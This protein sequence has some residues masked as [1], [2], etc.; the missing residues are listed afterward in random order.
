VIVRAAAPDDAE[1]LAVIY[2]HHVLTGFGTF[3]GEAPSANDMAERLA[4]VQTL[5]LPYLVAEIEGRVSGLA[6]AAPFRPRAAY[7]YTVED[8]IYV[9]PD[10]VGQ[11]VGKRLLGAVIETCQTLGFR[12]MVAM[13]GDSGNAASIA[14][15]RSL[16]FRPVGV[17]EGLGYKAGRWVDVAMMQRALNGGV[18]LPPGEG[19]LDLHGH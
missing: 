3:E 4:A 13:I 12:Q 7:R 10:R 1:A 6:Y 19:G 8:S 16:G 9:A 5:G 2:G 18:A 11:G 15:H 14:L 17:F